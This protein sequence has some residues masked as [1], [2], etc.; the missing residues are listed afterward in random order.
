VAVALLSLTGCAGIPSGGTSK[1]VRR[2]LAEGP[3]LPET[4]KFRRAVPAN[5][6][7]NGAP[8]DMVRGYLL[9]Q[10]S[11]DGD[12]AIARKYL[13]PGVGWN[14]AGVTVYQSPSIGRPVVRGA[15]ATV[16]ATFRRVGSIEPNGEFRPPLTP[17]STVTFTLRRVAA[18]WRLAA[19]PA[20]VLLSRDDLVSTF[21]RVT[22][23]HL[24]AARRLV[25]RPVFLRASDQP[26]ASVMRALL[27]GPGGWLGP[28]VRTAIP[29]GTELLDAPTLVD[30][31]ATL[32]FS[33][34]VRRAP[35]E[36]LASL[37]A[38]VVWTLTE[39]GLNVGSVRLLAEGEPLV[40]PGHGAVRE[41]VRTDWDDYAPVPATDDL[42]LFFVRNGAA[43]ALDEAGRM[44]RLP[45]TPPLSS[46]SV[47]R[48]GT[49]LAAVTR[50]SGGRQSLLVGTL[51][52][53]VAPH[54]VLSAERITAASWEPGGDVVWV[55][56][57]SARSVQVSAVTVAS[58]AVAPVAAAP[59]GT[60]LVLRLSPDGARCLLVV[61]G[62]GGGVASWVARVERSASGARRLA[63]QRA[64]AP[65]VT[66]VT[67]AA[68]E[69]AGQVLLA[70]VADGVRGLY[71]VDADGWNRTPAIGSHGLPGSPVTAVTASTASPPERIAS[72]A[73]RLWR[74]SPGADWA[75]VPG[76]G[77]AAAAAY[78]G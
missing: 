51:D 42:R 55:A 6:P 67:A 39:P 13:A 19:A 32:N 17:S 14:A 24:S 43:W 37:V 10:T 46:V 71:R 56:T 25:P 29:Q 18:G 2:V 38:Q 77:P 68:F 26:L 11:S 63:E 73:G 31:V 16:V 60:P 21:Q 1:V 33:R 76:T 59:G 15:T 70:G 22:L 48:P 8:D 44:S 40:V 58:G 5:P 62:A 57:T 41:S 75:P 34:E 3:D 7:D 53:S 30:G 20:G 69:G 23:Y 9:A 45:P 4:P 64:L 12:H 61:A 72:A 78:A 50:P 52:G 27:A 28:A 35:Q 65:S 36:T 54:A 66:S 49:W 74:R 47:N